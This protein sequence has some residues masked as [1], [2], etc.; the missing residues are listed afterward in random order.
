MA[1]K[2]DIWTRKKLEDKIHDARFTQQRVVMKCGW[3]FWVDEL[4][5]TL[6]DGGD[7]KYK[8]K[9]GINSPN[10]EFKIYMQSDTETF[11]ELLNENRRLRKENEELKIACDVLIKRNNQISAILNGFV[12]PK[13]LP[14]LIPDG[15]IIL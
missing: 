15:Q 3:E 13:S 14:F 9:F 4:F 5:Y 1:N 12:N 8:E 11:N 10:K 2:G 6:I 7:L